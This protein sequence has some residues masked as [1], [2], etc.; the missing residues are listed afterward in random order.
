MQRVVVVREMQ[1]IVQV[2]DMPQKE[3][4]ILQ[5]A[6]DDLDD[7]DPGATAYELGYLRDTINA[8]ILIIGE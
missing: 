1:K 5:D 4:E 2:F 7:V 6:I 3:C 8:D